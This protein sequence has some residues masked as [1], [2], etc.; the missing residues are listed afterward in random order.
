[1]SLSKT[2]A[3]E[4][5]DYNLTPDDINEHLEARMYLLM[6][7]GMQLVKSELAIVTDTG[8]IILPIIITE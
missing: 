6:P 7:E 3:E 4:H 1:M 8:K 5:R 2:G